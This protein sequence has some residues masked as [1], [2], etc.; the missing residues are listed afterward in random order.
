MKLLCLY[1]VMF[2]Y[3]VGTYEAI[4]KLPGVDFELWHGK[5]VANSKL[6]NYKGQVGFCH[7]ELYSLRLPIKTNNGS[8]SQPFFP[9]LFFRL[10]FKNPDIILAEGASSL[11]S[12]SVAYIYAKI[13]K[14]KII[15]WSMGALAGR[16]HRGIR[17]VA[18]RWIRH[19]ERGS[20]AIFAYSTQAEQFFL[21]EGVEKGRIFKAI[22]VIDI[23]NKLNAIQNNGPVVKESGFNVVF[24][25]AISKTKRLELLVDAITQLSQ[26]CHDI[27]LHIIGDG[28]YLQRIKEYV[29]SVGIEDHVIFHGRVTE[30][31]NVLISKYQ[32]LALPGLGG[33]AIV[34]GMISSLPVISGLADGTEKDLIDEG[35]GFVTDNMTTAYMVEKL[36]YLYNN[37]E[38]LTEM[39][40]NSFQKIT[41]CYSFDNYIAIFNN[42]LKFVAHEK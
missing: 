4:S 30:G 28:D 7:K 21:S 32:V 11:F 13:F 36:S 20:D 39:G 23:N 42:C 26:T 5:D 8:S 9:F 17:S 14:K 12:L 41:N 38:K 2:Q 15:M 16:R 35:N 34:D 10:A 40:E 31:L 24:V 33:L 19:I 1:Q 25:G 27:K 22:N 29:K 18:Q 3:R 6:K 37:P